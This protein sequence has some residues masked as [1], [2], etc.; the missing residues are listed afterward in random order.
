MSRFWTHS[1]DGI[2]GLE[3]YRGRTA[4]ELA[5]EPAPKANAVVHMGTREI[6]EDDLTQCL[7]S[8]KL[9]AVFLSA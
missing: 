1:L 6:K 5:R 8:K 7:S 2:D 4:E 9:A 3:C